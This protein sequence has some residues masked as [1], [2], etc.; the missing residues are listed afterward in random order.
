MMWITGPG[1]VVEEYQNGD[2]IKQELVKEMKYSNRVNLLLD[3]STD[4]SVE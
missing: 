3:A 4:I 1:Q 2:V